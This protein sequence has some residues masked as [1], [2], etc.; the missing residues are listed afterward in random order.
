MGTRLDFREV[1]S[2]MLTKTRLLEVKANA[3]LG[4]SRST[5]ATQPEFISTLL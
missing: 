3:D 1:S 4:P 2:L 5:R